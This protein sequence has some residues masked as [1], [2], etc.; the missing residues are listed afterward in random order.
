MKVIQ[1]VSAATGERYAP[2][3]FPSLK[4]FY[5]E[6]VKFLQAPAEVDEAF[7]KWAELKN[8][9]FLVLTE[10]VPDSEGVQFS[11]LPMMTIE[12][13][14]ELFK[15]GAE[16]PSRPCGILVTRPNFGA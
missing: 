12:H 4:A 1:I 3:V 2:V 13:L 6:L 9:Y 7:D 14:F 5:D 10:E 16:E 11:L 15:N 8:D